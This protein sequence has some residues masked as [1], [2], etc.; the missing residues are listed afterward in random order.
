MEQQQ[1]PNRAWERADVSFDGAGGRFT[2]AQKG[3]FVA[4]ASQP[5]SDMHS[6]SPHWSRGGRTPSAMATSYVEVQRQREHEA[7][8]SEGEAGRADTGSFSPP[9]DMRRSQA[10]EAGPDDT[11]HED[12]PLLWSETPTT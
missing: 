3:V 8:Q 1:Q 2:G 11:C 7:M 9:R 6:R 10:T 4:F 12:R 5:L